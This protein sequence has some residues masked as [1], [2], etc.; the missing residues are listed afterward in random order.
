MPLFT[1]ANEIEFNNRLLEQG[2]RL[3]EFDAK[4]RKAFVAEHASE[5]RERLACSRFKAEAEA[6]RKESKNS[7]ARLNEAAAS[8]ETA[9]AEKARLAVVRDMGRGMNE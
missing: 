3:D 4:D 9:D 6:A 7:H 2:K 1:E 5:F 8:A